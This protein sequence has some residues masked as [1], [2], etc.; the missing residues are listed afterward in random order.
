M[1]LPPGTGTLPQ[2]RKIKQDNEL[3]FL[4]FPQ[5]LWHFPYK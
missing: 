1:M 2:T 5:L 3:L 4:I